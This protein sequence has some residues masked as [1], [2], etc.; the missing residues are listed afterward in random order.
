MVSIA[1]EILLNDKVRFAITV[2]SLGFAI[3]M[4]VYDTGMFFGTVNESVN[5]IDQTPADL[6][7]LEEDYG[8]LFAPSSMPATALRWAR[9]MDGVNQACPLNLL[10]G[11]LAVSDT[12]HVQIVGIDPDCPL[13]RPWNVVD[14]NAAALGRKGTIVVDDF[15]LRRDP[16]QVGDVVELNGHELRIVAITHHNKGFTTPY[17]YTNLRTYAEVGGAMDQHAFVAMQLQPGADRGQITRRLAKAQPDIRIVES[18]E[19]R[20]ASITALIAQGVGMIFAV[21]L[22]GVVV[23]MLIITFTIY[24]ATVEQ[25]RSFA[26]LKALGATRWKIW[27]IVM[28]QAITQTVVSFGIGLAASLGLNYLIETASGIR[29]IFPVAAI[30]ACFALMIVLAIA[31]SLLSIGKANTVDPM[32]VFRA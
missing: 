4:I 10:M 20:L 16:A 22:I 19:F 14:G 15:I 7:L 13:V 21:V 5:L 25:L 3:V 8:D 11:T 1:R 31:G 9:R 26:I 12:H 18:Q 2:V 24:T 27:R 30:I 17:V 23:G 6:W 29:A 28:E 32:M